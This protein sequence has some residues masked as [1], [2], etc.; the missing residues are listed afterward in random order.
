MRH[1]LIAAALLAVGVGLTGCAH[2]YGSG[3]YDAGYGGY[4]DGY[5][6]EFGSPYWGWYG[7]YYYPGSGIYVYDQYRRPFRWNGSQQRYWQGRSTGRRGGAEWRGFDRR[8]GY[9][10]HSGGPGP[11]GPGPAGQGP[12]GQGAYAVRGGGQPR[13]QGGRPGAPGGGNSHGG[14]GHGGGGHWHGRR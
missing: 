1:P 6:D 12:A 9:A 5:G 11:T 8:G 13:F 10:G 3:Y 4:A 2:D 14:G 7:G